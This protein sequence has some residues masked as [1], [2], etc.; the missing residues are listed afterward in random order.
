MNPLLSTAPTLSSALCG[1]AVLLAIG[2]VG[3][4]T[5]RTRRGPTLIYGVSLIVSVI[6]TGTALRY[7]LNGADAQVEA[8]TLPIGLP[9][10][11]AH[12]DLDL[13][14]AMF[15]LVVNLGGASASLY[16]LGY[17]AH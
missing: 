11:G 2:I 5:A 3:I 1:I 12:F 4:F 14:A 16:G 13:L 9:W 17:G 8:Q 10:I 6:L 15:L 7:L